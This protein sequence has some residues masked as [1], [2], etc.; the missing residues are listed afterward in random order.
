LNSFQKD[1]ILGLNGWLV[2]FYMDF[3]DLI[4]EDLLRD[5]EE[6]IWEGKVLMNFN[7]TLIASIPK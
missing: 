3:F 1:K 5:V 4:E 2:E 6:V 7:S